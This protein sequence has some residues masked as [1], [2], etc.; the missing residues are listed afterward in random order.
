VTD[1]VV[2]SA[3]KQRKFARYSFIAT[4]DVISLDT[5]TRLSA[6]SSEL[7]LGG[8]YLDTLNP[9]PEGTLVRVR[10]TNDRGVFESLAKVVYVLPGFGMGIAFT[11]LP[12]DQKIV[13]DKWI[14][15]LA[16]AS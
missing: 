5:E 9:F 14:A 16:N 7:G 12:H 4:A 13:L 2:N 6:Q 10:L 8:C 11:H 3:V 15:E 1:Q